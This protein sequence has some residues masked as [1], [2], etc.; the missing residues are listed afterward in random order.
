MRRFGDQADG[1]LVVAAAVVPG[2]DDQQ[3]L[4][5]YEQ[6]QAL[7]KTQQEKQGIQITINRLT[8]KK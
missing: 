1:A 4:L 3:A 6:A 7:A 2:L 5:Y 8:G